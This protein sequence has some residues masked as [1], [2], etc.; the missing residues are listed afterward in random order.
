MNLIINA[1][2]INDLAGF[3]QYTKKNKNFI[4]YIRY[5]RKIKVYIHCRV[6]VSP[7]NWDVVSEGRGRRR[8]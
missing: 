4:S 5:L 2:S 8:G 3:C 6:T 1:P 7:N